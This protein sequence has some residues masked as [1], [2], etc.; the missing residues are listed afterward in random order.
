M[1]R[2][3]YNTGNSFSLT[4]QSRVRG[5]STSGFGVRSPLYP[6]GPTIPQPQY[7][8][9]QRGFSPSPYLNKNNLRPPSYETRY[10]GQSDGFTMHEPSINYEDR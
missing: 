3:S 7:Q 8:H 9:I 4:S 2:N 1:Y 5:T 10:L 6:I